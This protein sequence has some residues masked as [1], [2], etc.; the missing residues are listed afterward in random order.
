M[1]GIASLILAPFASGASPS[2]RSE[3][4]SAAR[5][6]NHTK[7]LSSDAFEG[8]A[9]GT[10]GE[11]KTVQY[12]EAEFR[13]L[14]LEPGNPDGSFLQGVPMVGITTQVQTTFA[15]TAGPLEPQPITEYVAHT[16]RV[17]PQFTLPATEVI[18][19]GY[20]V[21]APEYQWDD[22]KG[23]DVRGKTIVVLVNDPPQPDPTNR[24]ASTTQYS[25]ARR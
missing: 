9:P 15:T 19:C 20:G 10:P 17:V 13:Q 2:A 24:V 5:I 1:P 25:R 11:E 18:F 4:A 8:R 12:L 6:F 21:V 14:G 23:A 16:R 7:I 3:A 22:F